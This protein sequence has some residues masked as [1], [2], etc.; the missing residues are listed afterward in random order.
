MKR[1]KDLCSFDELTNVYNRHGLKNYL[2]KELAFA[3]RHDFPLTCFY[4]DLD[5]FKKINDEQ[6]HDIG[7]DI[8]VETAKRL[9]LCLREE[10]ILSRYGGD[11]FIIICIG[12]SDK[13]K[14][15][16]L[17][18]KIINAIQKSY[19][20]PKGSA[21][22]NISIG[23]SISNKNSTLQ[24]LINN[25]DIALHESKETKGILKFYKI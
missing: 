17:A 23:I 14:I 16:S 18:N 19:Q 24:S 12:L 6:G 7:D 25:A 5:L 10:D 1:F 8:L 3:I 21:Y 13:T 4:L 22:I 11:E 15:I 2:S 20:T 9:K